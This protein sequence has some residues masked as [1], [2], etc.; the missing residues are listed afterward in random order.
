MDQLKILFD[1]ILGIT[2]FQLRPQ[3]L[4]ID[5]SVIQLSMQFSCHNFP[6]QDK[7]N[8]KLCVSV[9]LIINTKE[10]HLIKQLFF[11]YKKNI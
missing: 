6:P 11:K 10:I 9:F 1:L 7:A 2:Q 5:V 3:L 4:S 8:K